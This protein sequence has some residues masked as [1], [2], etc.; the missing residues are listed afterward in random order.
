MT[1]TGP[2]HEEPRYHV[3][4][5]HTQTPELVPPGGQFMDFDGHFDDEQEA[6]DYFAGMKAQGWKTILWDNKIQGVL[7][8]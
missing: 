4:V 5:L 1:W 3:L 7:E 6:R 8:K 2:K